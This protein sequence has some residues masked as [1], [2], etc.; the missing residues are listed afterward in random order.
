M[1]RGD[2]KRRELLNAVNAAQAK[3]APSTAIVPLATDPPPPPTPTHKLSAVMTAMAGAVIGAEI[4]DKIDEGM[5]TRP[6][7]G[8]MF[9][10]MLSA[11][12]G[13]IM[14]DSDPAASSV[15]MSMSVGAAAAGAAKA[16]AEMTKEAKPDRLAE[17][18][19]D[20]LV[21]EEDDV[22]KGE[23]SNG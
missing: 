20:R 19:K 18:A 7:L 16:A 22:G 5:G 8:S 14:K 11:L 10:G 17:V 15:L 4:G 1:S 6:G 9:L 23:P 2:R 12:G 13:A 21:H 3:A